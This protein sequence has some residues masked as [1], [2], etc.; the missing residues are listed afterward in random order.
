MINEFRRLFVDSRFRTATSESNSDFSVELPFSVQCPAGS[1]LFVDNIVMS[2]SWPTITTSNNKV[3]LEEVESN[4][5]YHR[6]IEIEPGHYTIATIAAEL[7][8]KLR[9]GTF[10]LGGLYSVTFSNGCLTISTTS[11]TGVAYIYG[12]EDLN[13]NT[14]F[15]IDWTWGETTVEF[16]SDFDT[17]WRAATIVSPPDAPHPRTDA[18]EMIGIMKTGLSVQLG[19]PATLNYIDLQKHKCLYLCSTDLGESTS[20]TMRGSTDVI[21][22]IPVGHTTQGQVIVDTLSNSVAFALFR[23]D[24]ILKFLS[25]QI[26]DFKGDIVPLYDHDVSFEICICRPIDR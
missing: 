12:R 5:R 19:V 2:H 4:I 14:S 1:Q 20:M 17:V 7:Q 23:S 8:S 16:S 3:F 22:K 26:R 21:R 6:M 10:M 11:P 25:F 9:T 13:G 15:F 24:T 18:C